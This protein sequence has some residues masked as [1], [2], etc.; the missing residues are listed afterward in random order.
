[1]SKLTDK[2][3]DRAD[4]KKAIYEEFRPWGKYRSFPHTQASSIKIITVNPGEV[5]S[6]QYHS[7]RSEFWVILDNGLEVTAGNQVWQPKENEEVFIP[8]QMPHRVRCLGPK[9][10]RIMEIWIGRSDESDIVRLKDV[11][12]RK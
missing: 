10:A 9:P 5:L 1:L 12:G 2:N 6:L 3:K 11:Y 8:R 7:K 4:F